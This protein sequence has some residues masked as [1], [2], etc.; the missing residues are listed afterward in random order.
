MDDI[1]R[2]SKEEKAIIQARGLGQHYIVTDPE[3]PPAPASQRTLS[4]L[5][6]ALAPVLFLGGCVAG[7]A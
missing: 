2:F 1:R 5:L 6:K 7:T 4:T 3:I